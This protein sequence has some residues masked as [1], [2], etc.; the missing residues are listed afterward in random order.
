MVYLF[1][2]GYADQKGGPDNKK[3]YYKPFQQLL[4]KNSNKPME[5]QK[6]ELSIAVNEWKGENEQIDDILIMGIRL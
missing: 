6:E 2:D 4:I 5:Q 3:F 1:T